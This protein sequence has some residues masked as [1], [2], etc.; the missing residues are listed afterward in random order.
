[1]ECGDASNLAPGDAEELAALI[2]EL[3]GVE[4]ACG[5]SDL[6]DEIFLIQAELRQQLLIQH[7]LQVSK[8]QCV[9]I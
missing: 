8:R 6:H 5:L 2:K 9:L 7:E 4:D 1:M 3:A